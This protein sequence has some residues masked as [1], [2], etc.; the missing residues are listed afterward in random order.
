VSRAGWSA[1][2]PGLARAGALLL[3]LALPATGRGEARSGGEAAGVLRELNAATTR[4]A[5]RVSPAVVQVRATGYA[6]AGEGPPGDVGRVARQ[7]TIASGVVVDPAGYILT[8]DHVIHGA[9]RIQV[10][11]PGSPGR[12]GG[13]GADAR[14]RIF[15][16]RV[17]G[18]QPS[19]DM[20][21]LKI[22][23]TNLPSLP[24]EPLASVKQG[25]LVFA[26]GSPQGLASTVTMGVV[27]SAA[28]QVET[29]TPLA[30]P[31]L[32]VQTDAP[33][34]P[35]NSGGPLVNADGAL[36]GI[37][38]FIMSQSGG[39]QGLGFAIPAPMVK[40]AYESLRK[41][42]RV[43]RIEAGVTAQAVSPAMAAG[44]GLSRD[45]GVVVADVTPGGAADRA[46]LRPGDVLDAFDGRPIDSLQGLSAALY[47]HPVGEPVILQVLRGEESLR[48]SLDAPEATDPQQQ[49]SDLTAAGREHVPGLG[50]LAVGLSA[51]LRALLPPLRI[52]GGVI[53]VARTTES[54]AGDAGLQ[55][56]DVIHAVN[57]AP[58]G[59]VAELRDRLQA[60]RAGQPAVLQVERQGRL[61]YMVLEAE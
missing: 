18:T 50:V 4:L 51:S 8:N 55:V 28:R 49:L 61:A 37:N 44:L 36:V 23:A 12:E 58:V 42:G 26:I 7:T 35:G 39:S 5:A 53:V 57:G 31:M 20:A 9:Q 33:I 21:L 47:L 48:L 29:P 3:A 17:V 45:W 13:R 52:E 40:L 34:N 11:L 14:Q 54:A 10:V 60:P 30:T 46:G 15:R 59:S 1:T 56:G 2:G 16:A 43:R 41:Y 27:S 38:T 19:I 32:L 6:P 22:E 25:E 24:L